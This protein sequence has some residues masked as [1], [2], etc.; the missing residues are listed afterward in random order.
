MKA[1]IGHL[2]RSLKPNPEG[3]VAQGLYA[4]H[5]RNELQKVPKRNL[6]ISIVET[7]VHPRGADFLDEIQQFLDIDHFQLSLGHGNQSQNEQKPSQT[8]RETLTKLRGF[9]ATHN[10]DLSHLLERE[11]PW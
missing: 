5:I 11:I 9:Y 1:E 3:Y 4:Y 2:E 7:D 6:H 8:Q 10:K